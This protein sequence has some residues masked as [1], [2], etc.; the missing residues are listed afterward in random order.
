VPFDMEPHVDSEGNAYDF[1]F[2]LDWDG[3]IRDARTAAYGL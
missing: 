2:G 1:A 3:V